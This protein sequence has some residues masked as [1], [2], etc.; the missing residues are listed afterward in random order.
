MGLYDTFVYECDCGKKAESQTKLFDCCLTTLRVGTRIGKFDGKKDYILHLKNTCA[1]CKKS[2]AVIVKSG[3]I[4]SFS[5]SVPANV[6]E[7]VFGGFN[8]DNDEV[9]K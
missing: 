7:H 1:N 3:I 5:T 9:K 4:K 8:Y 2:S 6:Y